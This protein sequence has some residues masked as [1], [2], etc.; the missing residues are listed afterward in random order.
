MYN[1]MVGIITID[2]PASSGKGTVAKLVA[3]EL[4]FNY[5]DS[6]AIYRALAWLVLQHKIIA[7]PAT[8]A[9]IDESNIE[10]NNVDSMFNVG[11]VLNHNIDSVLNLILT[12]MNLQF[13]DNK[14]ILNGEDVTQKIRGEE[15]GN[16]ASTLSKYPQIRS[17]LLDF[18]RGFAVEQGLVTDGR[19]MGS[20]VFKDAL[21]KVFLTASVEARA[22]RRLKQLQLTDKSV[23]IAPILR[24]I[25]M[26]DEQDSSRKTAPLGYDATYQFLDNT[27]LTVTD[28]V[29]Q[30]L[31]WYHASKNGEG[32]GK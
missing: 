11:S 10:A 19:D 8:T 6:G 7:S 3:R 25:I 13:Q 15:I 2:G 17:A 26:R 27:D 23:I 18:Q 24:D 21:L 22:N 9:N 30:I 28:T 29:S 32:G 5:L 16:F 31:T 12:D 20:V 1:N 4:G 14:V